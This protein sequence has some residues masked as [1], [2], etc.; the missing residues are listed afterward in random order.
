[1]ADEG[2]KKVPEHQA[3]DERTAI[4]RALDETEAP[5]KAE[6]PQDDT[7]TPRSGRPDSTPDRRS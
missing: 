5:T 6:I 2:P 7:P 1:M 4:R 3:K